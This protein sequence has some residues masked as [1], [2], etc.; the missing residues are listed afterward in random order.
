M[1]SFENAEELTT[2]L[3]SEEGKEYVESL[4]GTDIF[5][6]DVT[7]EEVSTY[8]ESENGIK[9]LQ[10]YQDRATQKGIAS[11]LEKN[12]DKYIDVETYNTLKTESENEKSNFEKQIGQVKLNS[13]IK[14]ELLGAGVKK[15]Y[16]DVVMKSISQ[17][18]LV[19]RDGK[20][21]GATELV[22]NVT[23]N[24]ADLCDVKKVGI[25]NVNMGNQNPVGTSTYTKEQ[26]NT[27]SDK[28]YYEATQT[29]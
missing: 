20:L 27:M 14:D 10:P 6:R 21:V 19:L 8:L 17:E 16:V 29:K 4:R 15:K 22:A 2:L 11:H 25:G 28:E 24:Y 13:A 12:K 5:K 7:Q 26:L 1:P 3:S 18:G 23:E 9:V